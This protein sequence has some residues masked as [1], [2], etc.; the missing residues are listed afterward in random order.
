MIERKIEI[1]GKPLKIYDHQ[2]NGVVAITTKTHLMPVFNDPTPKTNVSYVD[3]GETYAVMSF[4]YT[5]GSE[6]DLDLGAQIKRKFDQWYYGVTSS[7]M[8]F[9]YRGLYPLLN[10]DPLMVSRLNMIVGV[11][12]P[13]VFRIK[14]DD[15]GARDFADAVFAKRQNKEVKKLIWNTFKAQRT[16]DNFKINLDSEDKMDKGTINVAFQFV[17]GKVPQFAG[18]KVFGSRELKKALKSEAMAFYRGFIAPHM[19]IFESRMRST[20]MNGNFE[21]NQPQTLGQNPAFQAIFDQFGRTASQE[22]LR[23]KVIRLAH[24]NPE[25]REHLLPLITEKTARTDVLKHIQSSMDAWLNIAKKKYNGEGSLR[26]AEIYRNT[27]EGY[28]FRLG[29]WYFLEDDDPDF[30]DDEDGD[31]EWVMEPRDRERIE[32]HFKEYMSSERWYRKGKFHIVMEAKSGGQT[33]FYVAP[34]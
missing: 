6:E 2:R 20:F 1:G 7:N 13:D 21:V 18:I 3:A 11:A 27:V 34:K 29:N 32:R 14:K 23:A 19:S 8:L 5:Y 16:F 31:G 33:W 30:F 15:G 26:K 9:W 25:L 28:V 22:S 24:Q 4:G 12:A 17:A 10:K